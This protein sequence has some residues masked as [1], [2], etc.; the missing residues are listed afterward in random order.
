MFGL[1]EVTMAASE[2]ER[3]RGESDGAEKEG[4]NKVGS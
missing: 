4:G 3:E 1:T 2:R